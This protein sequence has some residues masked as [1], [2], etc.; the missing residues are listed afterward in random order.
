MATAE[1]SS[2]AAPNRPRALAFY[3]PQFH[4]IPENDEWWGRGFTE[5]TNVTRAKPLYPGHYQPHVPGELGYYD[6]RVPEVREAQ[7]AL[8]AAHGIS[9]FVYYH[10]W[11]HG[12]RLLERPFDEVL[13]SGSPDFP[14]ALC[15][16]NEEWT[17]NWDA[18][19]GKVLMPQEFSDEDDLAHI[20]WLAT[21]FADDRYIKIDGRPL[22]LIYRAAAAPQ[23]E[24]DCGH[25]AEGG[26]ASRVP[27]SLSL[28]GRE[29][30]TA[31][32]WARRHTA[33]TP[34]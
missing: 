7:A 10:Y 33:S 21:A 25:L 16:A 12:T 9:G 34:A 5:W 18:Q 13:A 11:F 15:W 6:L 31:E 14:F 2:G 30:G 4:P 17:R 22:M 32:R 8:A 20:R 27:R 29:L 3:L 19:T 28:L 26:S 23:P 1:A 24:E